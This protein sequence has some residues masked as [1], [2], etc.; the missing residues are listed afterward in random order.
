ML[1]DGYGWYRTVLGP[2]IGAVVSR[3]FT[4][5]A[6]LAG[7]TGT[8]IDQ[9]IY[10]ALVIIVVLYLPNGIISLFNKRNNW[11]EGEYEVVNIYLSKNDEKV[12]RID[13]KMI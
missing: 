13:A 7:G 5:Y 10:G 3:Y 11:K 9:V 12:W 1:G 6:L 4:T 2:I 8:G